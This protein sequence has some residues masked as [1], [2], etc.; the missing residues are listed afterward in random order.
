VLLLRGR[1]AT[2]D[3]G[4]TR[5]HGYR[6]DLQLRRFRRSNGSDGYGRRFMEAWVPAGPAI[7]ECSG[8]PVIRQQITSPVDDAAT[9][10]RRRGQSIRIALRKRR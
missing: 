7:L 10:A 4:D 6:G 3:R 5:L 8:M 9:R 1:A 2:V